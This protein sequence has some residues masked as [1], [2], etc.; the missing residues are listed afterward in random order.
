MDALANEVAT[1]RGQEDDGLVERSRAED[2]L[3]GQRC[4]TMS[5]HDVIGG[6]GSTAWVEALRLMSIVSA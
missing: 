5:P 3:R 1:T 6:R 4:D 2:V